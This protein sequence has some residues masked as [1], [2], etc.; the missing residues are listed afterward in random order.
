MRALSRDRD[1]RYQSAREM[2][3]ALKHYVANSH[4]VFGMEQLSKVMRLVFED[5]YERELAHLARLSTITADGESVVQHAPELDLPV[6]PGGP[7]LVTPPN[8]VSR[9]ALFERANL[10]DVEEVVSIRDMA[11]T[12]LV[13]SQ[14]PPQAVGE[15]EEEFKPEST[16]S[17]AFGS[18]IVDMHVHTAGIGAGDSGCFVSKE[19]REGYKFGWYL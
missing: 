12:P 17:S 6:S 5:E 10:V 16:G 19:L 18:A 9:G 14:P 4:P 2:G 11:P 8:A 1:A 3:D 7:T 15:L 13:I